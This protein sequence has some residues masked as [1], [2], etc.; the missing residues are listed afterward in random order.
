MDMCV[1]VGMH[2]MGMGVCGGMRTMGMCV[3][4]EMRTNGYV[5]LFNFVN[6]LLEVPNSF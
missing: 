2:A 3:C 4:G 6:G 1:C 5:S